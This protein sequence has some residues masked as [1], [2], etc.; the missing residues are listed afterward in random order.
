MFLNINVPSTK[1]RPFIRLYT[2]KRKKL[3]IE[4]LSN[5]SPLLMDNDLTEVNPSYDIFSTNYLNL[6]NKYFPY[7]R[8]SQRSFKSKPF[9]TSGIKVSIKARNKLY[10]KYL[11]NKN[12]LTEATWK[13]FRNKT[14]TIISRARELYYNQL[15]K[16]HHNSSRQ[17]WKTF[18]KILNKNKINQRK[19]NSLNINGNNVCDPQSITDSFNNFFSQI[20]DNLAQKFL[21]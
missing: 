1:D 2:E 10:N 21:V 9:I 16:S 14:H 5:E 11:N 15:S 8:Q 17:L 13:R 6:F 12:E 18:G 20:G 7:V 19:I 3:F 4:N